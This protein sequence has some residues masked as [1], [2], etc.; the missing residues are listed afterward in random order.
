MKDLYTTD[1]FNTAAFDIIT[2]VK[3]KCFYGK[4]MIIL[5]KELD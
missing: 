4:A 5:E 2:A 1:L 3:H